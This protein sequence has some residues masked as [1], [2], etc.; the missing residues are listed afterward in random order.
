[1]KRLNVVLCGLIL[2]A[3]SVTSALADTMYTYTGNP[4]TGGDGPTGLPTAPFSSNDFVSGSF[5][6]STALA[7][8][9]IPDTPI[10]PTSFSFSNGV[11]T[12]TNSDPLFVLDFFGGT[13]ATG[14]LTSWFI[15]M[16]SADETIQIITIHDD[17]F[18]VADTGWVGTNSAFTGS[19]GTWTS[20]SDDPSPAATPEPSTLLLLGTGALGLAGTIRR[21]LAL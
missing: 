7:P 20:V 18:P 14:S 10:T 13:D 19:P 16:A 1:M 3:L 21:K 11:S 6:V 15:A 5:T 8:N 17:G 4:F 12:L 2:A 9:M